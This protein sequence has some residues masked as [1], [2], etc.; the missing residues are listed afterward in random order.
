LPGWPNALPPVAVCG[1]APPNLLPPVPV[2]AAD[3]AVARLRLKI[4]AAPSLASGDADPWERVP[5]AARLAA[6]PVVL[7][8]GSTLREAWVLGSIK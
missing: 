1:T 5:S 2:G 6:V 4:D 8:V 7:V 3:L